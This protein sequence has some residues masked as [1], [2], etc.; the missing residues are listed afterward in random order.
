MDEE[1]V[2]VTVQSKADEAEADF[3]ARLID[4]WTHMLRAYKEPFESVIAE[5][6]EFEKVGNQF[7]RQYLAEESVLDLLEQ[8]MTT[9]GI[10]HEPI[11]RDDTYSRYEAVPPEWMQI[12]H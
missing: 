3:S 8:E 11:D 1:L 4:F 2:C 5:S 12:E 10:D 6:T 7:T 9:A